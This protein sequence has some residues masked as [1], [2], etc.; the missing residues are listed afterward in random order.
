MGLFFSYLKWQRKAIGAFLAF[1]L[2]FAGVFALYELPVEAVGYGAVLC[3][4]LGV[5]LVVLDYRAFFERHKRLEALRREITVTAAGLPQPWGPLEEDYQAVIRVLYEDKLQ[6]TDQMRQRYTDLVEYYTVWAHQIKTPIAA[7]GLLLQ[8]EV[9]DTPHNREL[10]EE[11]Q[12]IE[13]YVEMVLC[14]LRLEAPATDYLIREYDLDGIV[15][16][17][18]RKYASQFI[19]RKIRLEYEPLN[20]RVLTDEK[21]L[22]FV[23]EQILSNA[24]KYTRSG[25]I[26]IVLAGPKIL[27]IRDTGMGIAPEDLPRIFEKGYTGFN[28]RTDKKASGI[29]LYLCRRICRNL[30]HEITAGSA[31]GRGTEIRLD[32]QSAELAIE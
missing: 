12:R 2:I 22:L 8:G 21:W 1:C 18:V 14:Y 31:A 20:C 27:C 19:R 29:G 28:G 32:L 5:I 16:Q 23:I 7:M 9:E 24:L 10:R 13:H 26:A 4:F 3:V 17:A 15:K 11:L 25:T 30:G 6:L